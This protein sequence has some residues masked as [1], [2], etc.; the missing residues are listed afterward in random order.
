[1]FF[2]SSISAVQEV[3]EE[4]RGWQQAEKTSL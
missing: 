2:D 3:F 1:M 4:W